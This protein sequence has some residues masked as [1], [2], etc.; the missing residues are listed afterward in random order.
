MTGQRHH[1]HKHPKVTTT[2]Q[3]SGSLCTCAY[4]AQRSDCIREQFDGGRGI[5]LVR[6]EQ[7]LCARRR[8]GKVPS[9]SEDA[10]VVR[11]L[12]NDPHNREHMRDE[13]CFADVGQHR[14]NSGPSPTASNLTSVKRRITA[15]VCNNHN[16]ISGD[17][18]LL[19]IARNSLLAKLAPFLGSS[20][21]T[22]S[23]FEVRNK[24]KTMD[25]IA[26]HKKHRTRAEEDESVRRHRHHRRHHRSGHKSDGEL[27]K[28]RM[29]AKI[30][31]EEK[32]RITST[33][34]E[35]SSSDRGKVK[36][37]AAA[38][39]SERTKR[40]ETDEE[41]EER[42]RRRRERKEAEAFAAM[43]ARVDTDPILS[44]SY[45]GHRSHR[46]DSERRSSRKE[47]RYESDREGNLR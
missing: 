26:P 22:Q 39:S 7:K 23:E 14:F 46:R 29:R 24:T 34:M 17:A 5:A 27:E 45:R 35:R 41:K 38:P 47:N 20:T 42:R 12:Q 36:E 33:H 44:D 10:A 9:S 30:R 21:N 32:E 13:W 1:A 19:Y 40:V 6:G 37:K 4:R 43:L 3:D 28:E 31:G 11:Q 2:P 8:S 18:L 25:M 15:P 16:S